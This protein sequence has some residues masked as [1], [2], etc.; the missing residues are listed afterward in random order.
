MWGWQEEACKGPW[1]PKQGDT[2]VTF[3]AWAS[4]SRPCWRFK[5]E[6]NET[7]QQQNESCIPS[8]SP[9]CWDGC[10]YLKLTG[11]LNSQQCFSPPAEPRPGNHGVVAMGSSIEEAFDYTFHLVRASEI[12]VTHAYTWTWRTLNNIHSGEVCIH[13]VLMSM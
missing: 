3:I 2:M 8:H 5:W 13:P 9:F 7:L 6:F 12:Q 4:S 11:V 1:P 10:K